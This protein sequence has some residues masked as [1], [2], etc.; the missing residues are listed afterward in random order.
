M[1]WKERL[2]TFPKV[3]WLSLMPLSM[4]E[5]LWS[6]VGPIMAVLIAFGIIGT[7]IVGW[8]APSPLPEA[9]PKWPLIIGYPIVFIAVL[10][11]IAAL[12]LQFRLDLLRGPLLQPGDIIKNRDLNVSLLLQSH[13]KYVVSNVTFRK[14][15]FIGPCAIMVKSM[16]EVKW[17]YFKGD[18]ESQLFEKDKP[19]DKS[20]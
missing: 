15:R 13:G 18:L 2:V 10:L 11:L 7:G 14:C 19:V 6:R 3:I 16:T 8:V 5:S 17:C 9:S 1:G 4:G 12:R 20:S